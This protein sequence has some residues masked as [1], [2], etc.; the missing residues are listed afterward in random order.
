MRRFLKVAR[1]A[2]FGGVY[3]K[4]L[5]PFGPGLNVVYGPNEAGKT[6]AASFVRG[7]LFGWDSETKTRNGY[8]PEQGDRSGRLLFSSRPA[9][10]ADAPGSALPASSAADAAGSDVPIDLEISRTKGS[11]DPEAPA[12]GDVAEILGDIDR[13]T[14]ET[15]F[16]LNV[17]SLHSL[18]NADN[19]AARFLTAGAGTQTSPAE[20][21]AFVNERI[22]SFRSTAAKN[23]HSLVSLAEEE[24]RARAEVA[25]ATQ[26]ADDA[27]SAARRLDELDA[28]RAG[29]AEQV[30]AESDRLARISSLKA[31]VELLDRQIDQARDAASD[32]K[33]RV[34]SLQF[35]LDALSEKQ[36]PFSF[37]GDL[38]IVLGELDEAESD[39]ARSA[40]RID[41]ACQ[42]FA[43]ATARD[44]YGSSKRPSEAPLKT[45]DALCAFAAA[46]IVALAGVGS[47]F[48]S[49]PL[50]AAFAGAAVFGAVLAALVASRVLSTRTRSG[51]SSPEGEGLDAARVRF[52]AAENEHERCLQEVRA[53][54]D[55]R[56][57]SCAQGSLSYARELVLEAMRL[58]EDRARVRDSHDEACQALASNRAVLD[59]LASR[60]SELLTDAGFDASE[61]AGDLEAALRACRNSHDAIADRLSRTSQERGFLEREVDAALADADADRAKV[62][63]QQIRTRRAES[64]TELVKLLVAKKMLEDALRVWGVASEPRLYREASRL[65][66]LMTSGAWC[67]IR[68]TDR[69]DVAVCDA[70]GIERSGR[71][72]SL[73][74]RQQMYLAL[75]IALLMCADDVGRSLPVLA[76]D[77]LVNFDD[78]RREGAARAL[79]ELA[80]VRQ[81]IVFTCHKE[82]VDSLVSADSSAIRVAL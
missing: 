73:G 27:R 70:Y 2:A 10:S 78:Q 33:V 59:S 36:R 1:I 18:A 32:A 69:G 40:D 79:A 41:A 72:L 62:R 42:A 24:K 4:T 54:L 71:N 66:S 43:E 46:A 44:Q 12:G 60:R 31:S 58:E 19:V 57:L 26:R 80:R 53:R 11:G 64:E 77:I 47:G 20:A 3:G 76:D 68:P 63:H 30:A 61:S 45:S 14:Y 25:E 22:E 13:D 51:A 81:V 49:Q 5:G 52:Q 67:T 8:K 28:E 74:T 35:S 9:A 37:E 50:P 48:I 39:L 65:M 38:R 15:V 75:R 23:D 16:A 21:L 29:L 56:G 17:D 6:T 82:V 55:G 7:V 34:D